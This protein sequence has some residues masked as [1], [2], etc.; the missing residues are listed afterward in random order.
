[1]NMSS[2]WAYLPQFSLV[3]AAFL[4]FMGT[5]GRQ[6]RSH[7]AST[8]EP[9][10]TV[11]WSIIGL[12]LVAAVAHIPVIPEHLHEAPYMGVLFI[13]FTVSAFGVASVLAAVPSRL[14]YLV[15]SALCAAGVLA[16]I[17][18]RVIAF[19]Q[20]ADDVGAWTEPLGLVSISAESVAAMLGLVA[21]RGTSYSTFRSLASI[22]VRN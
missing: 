17:A 10:N 6:S 2:Q 12:L 8:H 15:T 20:L 22:R 18:T 7:R 13:I 1:M 4:L 3:G 21:L 19:P 14:W 5:V 9:P 16:Y 11:R